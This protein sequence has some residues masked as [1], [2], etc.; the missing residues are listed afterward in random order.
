MIL[1]FLRPWYWLP[2][3]AA[4]YVGLFL[5]E[6]APTLGQ[7]LLVLAAAGAFSAAA[8][9]LNEIADLEIDRQAIPA[10]AWK[11]RLSA[12]SGMLLERRMTLPACWTVV[13]LAAAIGLAA[14]ACLS[15]A[16]LLAGSAALLLA[17]AYSMPPFRL[18]RWGVAGATIHV[19]GYGPVA[20]ALGA[21]AAI[22]RLDIALWALLAGSWVAIIGLTADL[23]DLDSDRKAGVRTLPVVLGHAPS[24]LAIAVGSFVLLSVATLQTGKGISGPIGVLP[25]FWVLYLGWLITL[26]LHLRRPLPARL[27][28]GTLILEAALPMV[29]LQ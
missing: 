16:T 19:V 22:M 11:V 20:M 27:H 6:P 23:L 18:K 12:G 10:V 25:L 5:A 28:L 14:C 9:G 1:L 2:T 7:I 29:A 4:A 13:G 8:E 21:G 3:L 24:V 17:V 15:R 26:L